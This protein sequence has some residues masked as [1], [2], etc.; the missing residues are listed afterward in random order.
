M[1]HY[2]AVSRQYQSYTLQPVTLRRSAFNTPTALYYPEVL[3]SEN[4]A[5]HIATHNCAIPSNT[6]SHYNAYITLPTTYCCL[7]HYTTLR[8]AYTVQYLVVLHHTAIP[9]KHCRSYAL[10]PLT[11]RRCA[12]NTP[13]SL[14]YPVVL[15]FD[16]AI[17]SSTTSH[18]V[19]SC[20]TLIILFFDRAIPNSTTSHLIPSS[21]TSH[22]PLRI[23][24]CNTVPH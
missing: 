4:S 12:S 20:S 8:G 1:Q 22:Y 5:T 16:R 19:P 23:A 11:V 15:L 10:L 2:V 14:Q 6:T 24:A 18:L 13:T 3:S 21:T 17:P 7:Q 9:S